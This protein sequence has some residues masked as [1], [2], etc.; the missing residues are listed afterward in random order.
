M[1]HLS[2]IILNDDHSVYHLH[3][4]PGEIS[5][6][7][8]TVGDPGRVEQVVQHFESIRVKRQYR[9]FYTITGTFAGRP[10]TVISTGIG[11]DNVDIVLNELDILTNV[12]LPERVPHPF[13]R[14]LIICRMGTSGAIRSNYPVGTLL[15]STSAWGIDGLQTGY[16]FG[17]LRELAPGV[18]AYHAIGDE[19][20]VEIFT[21]EGFIP[22]ITLTASGFYGPQGRSIRIP[23]K[24][25]ALRSEADFVSDLGLTNIE[26]ETA[27]IYALSRLLGHRAVSLNAILANRITG[28][29]SSK[30]EEVVDKMIKKGLQI[31]STL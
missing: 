30:P 6:L 1:L 21:N 10:M 16:D 7:I 28:E 3:L 18:M 19:R 11:T 27:G 31:L 23:S 8:I 12:L 13:P 14:S 20:L 9:E 15:V 24:L 22:G 5:D 25:S 4:H 17:N 2:E 29:F 26:M